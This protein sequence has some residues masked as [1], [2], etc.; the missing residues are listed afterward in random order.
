MTIKNWKVPAATIVFLFFC[1]GNV[2][3][4]L[5]VEF[6]RFKNNTV[7][8]IKPD[9]RK[10]R[11]SP[12]ISVFTTY[13]GQ[14][15]IVPPIFAVTFWKVNSSWQYLKCHTANMLIDGLPA[16]LPDSRHDGDVGNGYVTERI[17]LMLPFDT[18]R[19]IASSKVTEIRLCNDEFSLTETDLTGIRDMVKHFDVHKENS[20]IIADGEN[21]KVEM[22]KTIEMLR[23]NLVNLTE[24]REL[25]VEK[26]AGYF[27]NG[28]IVR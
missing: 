20:S 5:T 4:E 12:Q 25:V 26:C 3:A 19:Q 13:P 6:D 2:R 16:K 17:S 1:I 18:M 24:N 23:C 15:P 8:S 28:K 27:E 11:S 7:M 14:K 10:I 9:V 21:R 22:E